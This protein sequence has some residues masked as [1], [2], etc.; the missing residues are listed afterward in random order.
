M[1]PRNK[2]KK[3]K[4]KTQLV[5]IWFSWPHEIF[6]AF[7]PEENVTIFSWGQR[8]RVFFRKTLF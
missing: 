8:F 4:K 3:K 5:A 2:K 7:P 1:A 6:G